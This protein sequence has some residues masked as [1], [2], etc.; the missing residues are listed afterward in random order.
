MGVCVRDVLYHTLTSVLQ[1]LQ[2]KQL[3]HFHVIACVFLIRRFSRGRGVAKG[4]RGPCSEVASDTSGGPRKV[5]S[6]LCV[7]DKEV[8]LLLLECVPHLG[9]IED[10]GH[11][12]G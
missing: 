12:Q 8:V 4:S 3:G 5:A 11:L 2:P 7:L 10:G 1:C 6:N 9:R